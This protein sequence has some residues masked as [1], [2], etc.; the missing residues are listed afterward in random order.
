MSTIKED[1]DYSK[2]VASKLAKASKMDTVDTVTFGLETDDGK[3]VKVYVAH[4]KSTAF[5]KLLSD[6]LGEIDSIQDVLNAVG[7]EDPDMIIDV[8]WPD[9]VEKDDDID[10][11]NNLDDLS[12]DAGDDEEKSDGSEALSSE[13][14]DNPAEKADKET[15]IKRTESIG[16]LLKDKYLGEGSKMKSEDKSTRS[17]I[18][19]LSTV[20]Q[21][22][23]YNA[24]LEL[25]IKITLLKE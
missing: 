25:K 11:D 12:V 20:Q 21:K 10:L 8:E 6:K 24:W 13:I 5:E 7:Q 14:Y 1:T 15:K 23:I 17:L 3:I 18:K 22:T 19:M 16:S 4:E 2:L 9:T